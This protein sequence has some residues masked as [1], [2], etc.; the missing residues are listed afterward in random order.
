MCPGTFEKKKSQQNNWNQL[1]KTE[2]KKYLYKEIIFLKFPNDSLID[3]G[4]FIFT[5]LNPHLKDTSY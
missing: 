5:R 3:H 1:K 2:E 4:T